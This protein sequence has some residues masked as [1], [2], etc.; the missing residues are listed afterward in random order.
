MKHTPVN[1]RPRDASALE[2]AVDYALSSFERLR[3]A[4]QLLD[5][6]LTGLNVLELGPGIEFGA[7]LLLA[8]AGAN[9]S[10]ADPYLAIWD[11]NFHP[12]F[13]RS[14]AS[15]YQGPRSQLDIV[16]AE[17][18]YRSSN[19]TLLTEPAE[20][21]ASI[22][23]G[24]IDLIC[25]YAVLEHVYDIAAVAAEMAR[26]SAPGA[27]GLHVI[28]L[29]DHRN[30]SRPLEHLLVS[31][32][33]HLAL[34][35]SVGFEFGNR[36]RASEFV[37]HF[38]RSGLEVSKLSCAVPADEAYITGF[39]ERVR[40]SPS[41]YKFWP[42]DDL[43]KVV[44]EVKTR[45]LDRYDSYHRFSLASG[46]LDVIAALKQAA[47]ASIEADPETLST[48]LDAGRLGQEQGHAWKW[49]GVELPKGDSSEMPTN[50]NLRLF[51]DNVELGPAH[52]LHSDIRESGAGRF[53]H[54]GDYLIFSTSDNS[55]PR[56]NGRAYKIVTL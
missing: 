26:V 10:L 11:E 14:L 37:A 23:S 3:N 27:A 51:E 36:V 49:K 42:K 55:D 28:D 15:R 29:R 18:S 35:S 20:N 41:P 13:Y 45:R 21:M 44:I 7:Q 40:N 54:W 1:L 39:M 6:P 52:C 25:S 12:D 9:V 16:I 34:A 48:R 56:S 4:A 19:L 47:S 33:H 43:E 46:Y 50:S 5:Q 24:A 38:E 22:G 2:A 32:K 30:F 8:S 17:G 53:S 31:D